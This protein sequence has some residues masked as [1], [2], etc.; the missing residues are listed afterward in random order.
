MKAKFEQKENVQ[1]VFKKKR[2]VRFPLF[3]Q[4][5]DELDTRKK[6]VLYLKLT[7]AIQYI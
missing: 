1:P 3:K 5:N 4:I 6:W 7:I 2:N